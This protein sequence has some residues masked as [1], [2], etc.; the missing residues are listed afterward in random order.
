MSVRDIR[1]EARGRWASMLPSLGVDKRYLVNRH[2][3]CPMCGGKDRFRFDDKEGDG[4]WFC[5]GCGAGDGIAL[6]MALNRWEFKEAVG[7]VRKLTGTAEVGTTRAGPSVEEVKQKMNA[8]WRGSSALGAVI[9]A[10]VWLKRR[11]CWVDGLKDL[12]GVTGLN[13]GR[14][15]YPGILAMVRD[16][17][18]KPVNIHRTYLSETGT[19]PDD[20][21]DHR[22]VMPIELPKGCAV[23]LMDHEL[24]LGVA[25]GIE[26][27]ISASRLFGVPTWATLNA[28][29]MAEWMAPEG[30]ERVVI[31]ADHDSNYAGQA[32]AFTLAKRLVLTKGL[33]VRVEIPPEVDQD[34]NDVWMKRGAE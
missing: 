21:A 7:E 2:G 28:G 24:E 5:N 29:R 16:V 31:F 25:E 26:T 18:G 4:T 1:A 8:L 20:M 15:L 30:V 14:S 9:P 11:G 22:R 19:K 23:R 13:F 33:S 34:W 27:S 6:V 12:R 10:R 32:A 17:S 3:P